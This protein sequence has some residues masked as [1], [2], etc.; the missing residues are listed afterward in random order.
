MYADR[1]GTETVTTTDNSSD[2]SVRG[3][4]L[5]VLAF[6]IILVSVIVV[7]WWLDQRPQRLLDVDR[8][9]SRVEG[10][11]NV[12]NARIIYPLP[13]TLFPPDMASPAICWA[14]QTDAD[15]WLV[16]LTSADGSVV[17]HLVQD[18]L[19][20]QIPP[21]VWARLAARVPSDDI[22]VTVAGVRRSKPGTIL[23]S[24]KAAFRIS[25]HRVE[26]PI[27]Y[28]EVNLP[29][30]DAVR[31]PRKIR[32]RFGP[33]SS[34]AQ[35]PVVLENLPVCGNC[36]SFSGDGAVL[37]MDIDYANDKGSY[38]I[39]PVAPE[40]ALDKSSIINW[41]DYRPDSKVATF[42]L[43]SRVSPD[44]RY[45][46][47]TV[48]DRSVFVPMPDLAFSQLFFPIRGI[49][50]VYDR[51]TRTYAVL[52]GADNP[53]YVQSNPVW[54]PDG[55]EIIFARSDAY[56][57]ENESDEAGV[58]LN[59]SQVPE[60][61]RDG[62]P[63]RYDL[64]RIPFNDGKGGVAEPVKGA[65]G[66]GMSNY[67]PKFSP[68]GR[69]IVFC[70]A[71]SYML[72]QPDSQLYIIPAGGGAPRRLSCN[73]NLMNSW[74]SWSP[75]GKWLVFSSKALG[76][77]TQ[78]FLTHIDDSGKST[79]PVLLER[80]CSPDRAA[81]IPEFVNAPSDAIATI[82]EA[83]MDDYSFERAGIEAHRGGALAHAEAS[84][85][86]AVA[87]N[88]D[89]AGSHARLAMLLREQNRLDE[90]VS[91]YRE[92]LRCEP[93]FAVV[94]LNL[95]AL[96][97]AMG[98]VA[99][100]TAHCKKAEELAPEDPRPVHNLGVILESQDKLDAAV[101]K[102]REALG[103]YAKYAEAVE[104]LASLLARHPDLKLPSDDGLLKPAE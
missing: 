43:L 3:G 49:L 35:P 83:F 11:G 82:H 91:E 22:L 56:V 41:R 79:P 86:K 51:Q 36:H 48:R 40:I 95:S 12:G 47:S 93:D 65:S 20:W 66:D 34:V 72:L 37:G 75:N 18:G 62:K 68:D 14:Q 80:F 87:L 76:P 102:Y 25:E 69:W 4:R 10:A 24:A 74:H 67:F 33:V 38:A 23:C 15:S 71:S 9:A 19:E 44:G 90:A 58:L 5:P 42:G 16:Q 85:R 57:L 59:P 55:R 97:F 52:P 104:S 96:L 84:Y 103:L 81:N 50:T 60:F 54:S 6:C 94:H 89:R 77:Y 53:D 30:A 78:L 73:T 29:F 8:M 92:A 101:C 26:A 39:V 45:V 21:A 13:G 1:I 46:I 100:A 70:K 31:D 63:F 99:A 32:W 28:R 88:P 98:D 7:G 27:M 2:G 64:Y 61:V 17:R